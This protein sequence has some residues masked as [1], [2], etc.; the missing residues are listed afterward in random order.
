MAAV[1]TKPTKVPA[2]DLIEELHS[3]QQSSLA[4]EAEQVLGYSGMTA[5]AKATTAKNDLLAI[6][7]EHE[8]QVYRPEEVDAYKEKKASEPGRHS[9]TRI[10]CS[11]ATTV[12]F[13]VL[14]CA[15]IAFA[16]APFGVGDTGWFIAAIV[17]GVIGVIISC[18]VFAII[19]NALS[20]VTVDWVGFSIGKFENPIPEKALAM[21]VQLGRCEAGLTFHVEELRVTHTPR[22][23]YDPLL[24]VSKGE[25]QFCIAV[26]DEP[27]FD[28]KLL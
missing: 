13:I 1:A 10:R 3:E 7:R 25:A 2:K 14:C 5:T 12:A 11:L 17:V 20:G 6:L 19:D 28:A 26:W 15:G 16:W 8:I 9:E 4:T 21:A 18:C 24:Y 22:V 27:G 23:Y